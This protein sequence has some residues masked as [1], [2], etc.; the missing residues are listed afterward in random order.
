[1]KLT[2]FGH[3]CV[4]V[5]LD[6]GPRVL[7][8]PGTYSVGFERCTSLEAILLTHAHPD[9]VDAERLAAL[10]AANPQACLVTNAEC[11]ALLELQAHDLIV[12]PGD[13]REVAGISVTVTGGSHAEIHAD[14]PQMANT[15]FVL[16]DAVWHPGDGFGKTSPH[17]DVLLLP[18]AGPWMRVADAIN[19]A[20][21]VNPR[22]VVPIHQAGLAEVHRQLHY[23][24]VRTLVDADLVVLT[25][26]EPH[27]VERPT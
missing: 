6:S 10:R 16:D 27:T 26:H 14:L 9:H 21:E 12:S 19:F 1:M 17:V 25:E 22:L 3:A 11:G 8:D 18:I 7:F 20:R 23:H 4:L 24:L 15:G 2:H 5:E 13:V